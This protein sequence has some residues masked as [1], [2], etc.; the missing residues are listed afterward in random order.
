[1][2]YT[3]ELVL[4]IVKKT[5][6]ILAVLILTAFIFFE[7]PMTWLYGYIFGGA[8]GILNFMLLAKTMEKAVEMSPHKAQGYATV[9][10]FIRFAITGVVLFIALKADYINALA[11]IVG[12]ILIKLIILVTNLFS[13]KEYYKRI[14][15]RKGEN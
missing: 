2:N 13:D 11:V 15:S 10:Y 5:I 9:N 6:S 14:F 8:I 3:A 12:L 7:E 1:L 4:S